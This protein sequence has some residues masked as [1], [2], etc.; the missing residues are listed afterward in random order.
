MNKFYEGLNRK[1]TDSIKWDATGGGLVPFWIADS[2]YQTCDMIVNELIKRV[3]K[4]SFGYTF[5]SEEYYEAIID[6]MKRY[7]NVKLE[8]EW[9][10]PS[11]GVV[12]ALYLLVGLFTKESDEV[13]V[14][15]PVY[16]P[17]YNVINNNNRKLSCNKLIETNETYKI[18]FKDLEEKMQSAKMYILCNPHN[19]IGRCWRKEEL[20]EIIK[21]CKK[22][23][24]I[25]VSDEIH[26]DIIMEDNKFYSVMNYLLD[27][28]K[29]VVCTAPSKTFNI[30]GLETANIIIKNTEFKNKFFK[31]QQD[32]SISTPNLLGLTA[33]KAAYEYGDKW[34]SEQNKYLKENRDL[35]YDYFKEN[36]PLAKV[37]KLEG[38]YLMWINLKFLG[39]TQ[40]EIINGLKE[41]GILVNSGEVYSN[42]YIGY[43]RF[44]IACGRKQLL[45]GLEAIKRF[46]QKNLRK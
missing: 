31:K 2:D 20:D 4:L 35:V 33:C 19:P 22:Y 14:S 46:V 3:E 26:S 44:N 38:T 29:I 16:N 6:W 40:D 43:I 36:I 15:T 39:L 30:A 34:V 18:D 10:V 1:G 32:M 12:T 28:E 37:Y 9:I 7:H 11:V 41:E 25:L 13:L 23:D 24:V 42:D 45:L 5:C 8:K 21:L 27:Y 17:F